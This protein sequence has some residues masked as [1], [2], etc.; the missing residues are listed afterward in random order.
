MILPAASNKTISNKLGKGKGVRSTSLYSIEY[1][2]RRPEPERLDQDYGDDSESVEGVQQTNLQGK[3]LNSRTCKPE[4][5][6][7]LE[8]LGEICCL[9]KTG[10]C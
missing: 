9:G 5:V 2:P 4:F 8:E 10:H 6:E 3:L 1:S 7:Y